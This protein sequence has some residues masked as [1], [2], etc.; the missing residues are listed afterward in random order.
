[1]GSDLFVPIGLVV[2]VHLGRDLEREAGFGGNVD[3]AI[4]SFL[5]RYA[6]EK[7]KVSALRLWRG[8]EKILRQPVISVSSPVHVGWQRNSLVERDG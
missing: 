6:S 7:G 5:R 8:A 3:G 1:M 4:R 2:L